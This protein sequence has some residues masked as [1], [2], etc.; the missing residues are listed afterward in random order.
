MSHIGL[1]IAWTLSRNAVCLISRS[2]RPKVSQLF[3]VNWTEGGAQRNGFRGRQ[4]GMYS[5]AA[6]LTFFTMASRWPV[7]R[8][9]AHETAVFP[10]FRTR[11]N[12]FFPLA[13]LASL[14]RLVCF[15][16]HSHRACAT[17]VETTTV[18]ANLCKGE[19]AAEV[20]ETAQG[21]VLSAFAT[22]CQLS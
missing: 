20:S 7:L 4:P 1:C 19:F 2:L 9:A 21:F 17:A 15:R 16:S 10:T 14:T 12:L 5:F 6:F 18:A 11:Q 22:C 13:C 3:V 8:C